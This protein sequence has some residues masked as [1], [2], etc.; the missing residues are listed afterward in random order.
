MRGV[1]A[2]TP[3]RVA[4]A[5]AMRDSGAR[6]RDIAEAFDVSVSTAGE[7]VADPTGE[8]R[9]RRKARYDRECVVCGGRVDGTSPGRMAGP[10][11]VCRG[12]A[13]GFYKVWTPDAIV[14]AIQEWADEHGGVPPSASDW[15]RD[16]AAR[17]PSP[18]VTTCQN[19]F[20]SWSA[21][22][23]AAGFEPHAMGPVGGFTMLT[24]AQRRACAWRYAAGESTSAI[25]ADFG[26][27]PQRVT[28]WARRFGVPIRPRWGVPS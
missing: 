20:G 5:L 6:L 3:Q 27:T 25:S 13:P 19:V 28:F 11:A 1:T 8:K 24:D 21:A 23:R 9:A 14:C 15:L 18:A 10:D 2:R 16:A 4:A 7:W 17:G 22:I 26:C 12:C